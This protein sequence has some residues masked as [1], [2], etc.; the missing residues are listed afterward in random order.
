MKVSSHP[1]GQAGDFAFRRDAYFVHITWPGGRHQ[2]AIDAF[3]RALMR[4]VAWG[5]FYGTVN[6]DS[7]FGTTNYYGEV[8]Y[9]PT[10]MANDEDFGAKVL[11]DLDF[12]YEILQGVDLV[13]GANN[14]FNTFPDEH[15]KDANRSS[16]NFP[17]SR[18]V[19][20]FGTNG[21]YYYGELQFTLR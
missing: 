16:G 20:Q 13:V 17:Y 8:E 19:T 21:G 14:V 7:V 2:M 6:F 1:E 12:G 4:D 18:R 5:F 15:E 11:V 3:L 10:D 9:R